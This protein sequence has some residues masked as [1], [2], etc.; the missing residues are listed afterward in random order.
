MDR[1]FAR[2]HGLALQR[3]REAEGRQQRGLPPLPPASTTGYASPEAELGGASPRAAGASPSAAVAAAIANVFGGSDGERQRTST[4]GEAQLAAEPTFVLPKRQSSGSDSEL[5]STAGAAAGAAADEAAND[6]A[7]AAAGAAAGPAGASGRRPTPPIPVPRDQQLRHVG[8]SSNS[9]GLPPRSPRP[10]SASRR[11][12]VPH[13][14]PGSFRSLPAG[15]PLSPRCGVQGNG[16]GGQAATTARAAA[17]QLAQ[18]HV[19]RVQAAAA[20]AVHQARKPAATHPP[21][22]SPSPLVSHPSG[23]SPTSS[24]MLPPPDD[25]SLAGSTWGP[26]SLA[27]RGGANGAE[28]ADTLTSRLRPLLVPPGGGAAS[29]PRGPPPLAYLRS[30]SVTGSSSA[31]GGGGG[32]PQAAAGVQ[33]HQEGSNLVFLSARPESY[34]VWGVG[35]A[36]GRVCVCVWVGGGGGGAGRGGYRL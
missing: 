6:A 31:L 16:Q 35:G 36:V 14:S 18:Q 11:Q 13:M 32:D 30:N 29:L 22:A 25:S 33:P 34:K 27:T 24:G 15:D 21:L 2:R 5:E 8:S 10:H 9:M 7:G 20:A 1:H 26:S 3:L 12:L 4:A 17:D 19:Q 28:L 23:A